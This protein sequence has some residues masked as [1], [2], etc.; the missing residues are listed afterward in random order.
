MNLI[1]EAKVKLHFLSFLYYYPGLLYLF[2]IINQS[3]VWE[4]R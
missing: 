2:K 4:S 1:V 3:P